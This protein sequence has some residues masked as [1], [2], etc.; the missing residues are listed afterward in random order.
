VWFSIQYSVQVNIFLNKIMSVSVNI[1]GLLLQENILY[2]TV[3]MSL[4]LKKVFLLDLKKN[5]LI[6]VSKLSFH[7]VDLTLK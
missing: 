5:N 7:S 3:I 6:F 2:R 1:H 4:I